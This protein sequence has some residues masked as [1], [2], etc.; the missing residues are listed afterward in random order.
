MQVKRG[1]LGT[2]LYLTAKPKPESRVVSTSWEN[3]RT[4]GP[5]GAEGSVR[6]GVGKMEVRDLDRFLTEEG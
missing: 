4:G 5:G 2:G 6:R 1:S 3:W